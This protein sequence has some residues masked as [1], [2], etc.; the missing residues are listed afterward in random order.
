MIVPNTLFGRLAPPSLSC[1]VPYRNLKG[2]HL[3]EVSPLVFSVSREQAD[4]DVHEHGDEGHGHHR[5]HRQQSPATTRALRRLCKDQKKCK[6][7]NK[8]HKTRSSKRW[9]SLRVALTLSSRSCPSSPTTRASLFRLLLMEVTF[10][11]REPVSSSSSE[12]RLS[13]TSF[14]SSI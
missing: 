3:E 9:F 8:N 11:L 5:T 7:N 13:W 1:G 10:S 14:C 4:H 6:K 2:G 12:C